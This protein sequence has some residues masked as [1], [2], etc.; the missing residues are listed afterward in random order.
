LNRNPFPFLEAVD[1]LLNRPEVDES[2]IKVVFAGQCEFHGGISVRAWSTE[3][4]CG[5]VLTIH[6]ALDASRLKQIYE[7]ATLLL[8]FAEGQPIQVPAKT[9]EL[10]SLGREVLVA[11][12]PDSDTSKVVAGIEGVFTVRLCDTQNLDKLMQ[13]IY[14]RHVVQ[15][16]MSP[17]TGD[18]VLRFSRAIQ[19]Q[20]Y[21]MLIDSVGQR[22]ARRTIGN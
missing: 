10:L 9:F 11:C 6:P 4:R 18:S 21:R 15:G 17:P 20:H 19:N 14:Q 22:T 1:R 8:N 5:R 3:R 7:E 12:E 2:R 16:N 13:S